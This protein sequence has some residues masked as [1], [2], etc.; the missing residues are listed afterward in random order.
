MKT[1]LK[2]ACLLLLTPVTFA[3]ETTETTETIYKS[4]DEKGNVSYSTT[5]PNDDKQATSIDIK[6]P[7]SEER[8]K[9]AQDRHERNLEAA[10]ILDGNRQTRN[11][12]TAEE[13]RQKREN[14]KRLQQP[15]D[16]EKD[17][18]NQDNTP[19]YVF[20]PVHRQPGLIHPPGQGHTPKYDPVQP[21]VQRPVQLPAR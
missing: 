21:P 10:D 13:N 17:N 16:A 5:T 7:P 4:I 15:Q 3:T 18:D 14:Q 9:T 11:E 12:I 6:P 8:I 20:V 19:P 2:L 1:L